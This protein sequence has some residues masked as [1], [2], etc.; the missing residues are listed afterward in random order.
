MDFSKLLTN[1][2]ILEHPGEISDLQ[3]LIVRG[4][5]FVLVIWVI[6][7]FILPTQIT[8][9]LVSRREEIQIAD[10]QVKSTLAETAQMRDDYRVRLEGIEDETEARMAEAVREAGDIRDHILTEAKVSAEAIVRRGEDEVSRERA[11][12]MVGLRKQFVA[13]VIGAAEHT[14]A[15]MD[16][17]GHRRLVDLFISEVGAKS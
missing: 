3:W 11:K 6:V 7:K 15:Q 1:P 14:A 17:K 12:A 9:H 4:I 16:D 13:D 5:G 10:D 2:F 8:P